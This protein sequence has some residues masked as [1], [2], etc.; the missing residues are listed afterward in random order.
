V[1]QV[2]D[3]DPRL[4]RKIQSLLAEGRFG[5]LNEFVT[6]AIESQ[7]ML[8]SKPLDQ[9]AGEFS[10]EG[11]MANS[12]AEMV[13]NTIDGSTGVVQLSIPQT[14]PALER[15]RGEISDDIAWGLYNRIFP[16]K[17]TVRVLSQ[18]L[19]EK[20]EKTVDLKLLRERT[21]EQAR[22]V[23]HMLGSNRR[24]KG[25]RGERLFTGLPFRRSDRS[26]DRFENMFV[27]SV[28]LKG[29]AEGFPALLGFV[30]LKRLEGRPLAS[31]TEAGFAFA[32]LR[33]PVLDGDAT[34]AIP[35]RSLSEEEADFYVA[36]IRSALPREWELSVHVLEEIG[37]GVNTTVGI[38]QVVRKTVHDLKSALIPP[39][40][41]GVISRLGELGL[42]QRRQDGAKV[43]YALTERGEA[44]LKSLQTGKGRR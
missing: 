44:F 27:G 16:V 31:L 10:G 23:A 11:S 24:D 21:T 20:G 19:V 39:T 17:I 26:A 25:P 7:I 13:S 2:I 5:S 32:Q 4:W 43:L 36:H 22:M 18:L 42:V 6:A 14:P 29:K 33:N 38:D 12:L 8:E 37:E 30:N 34:A 1:R 9:A 28:S 35:N 15:L 3:I 40:R 41:S